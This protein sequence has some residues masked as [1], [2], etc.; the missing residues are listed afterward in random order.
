MVSCVSAVAE[1]PPPPELLFP[2][3]CDAPANCIPLVYADHLP[4]PGVQDYNCG[5]NAREQSG[6]T[7]IALRSLAEVDLNISVLAAAR[8]K[9]RGTRDGIRDEGPELRDANGKPPPFCGNAVEIIHEGGWISRYCHMREGSV[10]VK[11]GDDLQ[12]GDVIGYAGWSGKAPLPGLGFR[13]KHENIILDPF[14]GKSLGENCTAKGKPLWTGIPAKA[15]EYEDIIVIDAG[16]SATPQPLLPDIIRGYHRQTT[17]PATAPSLVFWALIGN[18]VPGEQRTLQIVG[19]DDKIVA[20]Q[21][22]TERDINPVMLLHTGAMRPKQGW[23]PGTYS[24]SIVISREVN[25]Q[26]LH[27]NK[28]FEIQVE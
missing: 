16:F 11:A 21:K 7:H 25:G 6:V 2:L 26:V 15:K 27:I 10:L 4:G 28:F 20:E 8:G 9:V 1:T 23:L 5:L 18:V 22:H 24:A 17:L 14:T 13:L 3:T 12:A 19:P